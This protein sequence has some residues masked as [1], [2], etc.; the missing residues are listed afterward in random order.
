MKTRRRIWTCSLLA[1]GLLLGVL[2]V[3]GPGRSA[4]AGRTVT[5]ATGDVAM[6]SNDVKATPMHATPTVDMAGDNPGTELE[7]KATAKGATEPDS[8]DE[9]AVGRPALHAQPV[10]AET[11]K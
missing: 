11:G 10:S 5:P 3:D 7:R 9:P 4:P 1:I 8:A 2:L 6:P